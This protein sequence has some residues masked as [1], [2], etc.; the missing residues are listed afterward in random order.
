M[1]IIIVGI[2]HSKWSQFASKSTSPFY[3][4]GEASMRDYCMWPVEKVVLAPEVK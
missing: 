1:H 4:G 2:T 3:V